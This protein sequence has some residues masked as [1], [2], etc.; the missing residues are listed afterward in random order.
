M[1][2]ASF[3]LLLLQILCCPQLATVVVFA[4][5]QGGVQLTSSTPNYVSRIVGL[6]AR[7]QCTVANCG[8]GGAGGGQQTVHFIFS[9]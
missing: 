7:F 8:G 2:Q 4:Q 3:L 6:T 1:D 9:R 5:Q